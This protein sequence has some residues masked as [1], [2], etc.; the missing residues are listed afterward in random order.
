MLTT[1]IAAAMRRAR[2]E[3]LPENE[4]YFGTID[5][6]P[7]V[8]AN[9]ASLEACRDQLQE[10]LEEWIVLGLRMEH[11]LPEIDGVQLG[12]QEAA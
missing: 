11:D 6:L 1:Y 2:Y 9:A 4:G 10:V 12:I 5:L 8:W 7:G 3:I